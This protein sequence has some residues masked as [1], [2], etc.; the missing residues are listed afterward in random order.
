MLTQLFL[1]KALLAVLAKKVS[2]KLAVFCGKTGQNR[3]IPDIL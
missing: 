3:Q 2:K 1:L